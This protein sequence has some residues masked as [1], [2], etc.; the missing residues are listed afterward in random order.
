MFS[1]P[2]FFALDINRLDNAKC[3]NVNDFPPLLLNLFLL[4]SLCHHL[5]KIAKNFPNQFYVVYT[6]TI[7]SPIKTRV[8]YT[9]IRKIYK[10]NLIK[11]N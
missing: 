2:I 7:P 4:L 3:N 6:R 1:E 9:I 8:K 10:R 5:E 11:Q